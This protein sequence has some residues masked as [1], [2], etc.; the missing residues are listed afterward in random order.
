MKVLSTKILSETQK[1]LFKNTGIEV[2]DYDAISIEFFDFETPSVIKNGI[3]TSQNGVQS[4][5]G[6]NLKI[7][8]TFC[9]GEKTK[10]ILQENG[11]KVIK[12][13]NYGSELG[14][15]IQKNYENEVFYFFCGNRR[16]D[17]IP[18]AI[19]NSKNTL[20]EIKTYKT[21]LNTVIF[22]QKWD[23]ILFFSPS[24]VESY[25]T[26][27]SIDNTPVF[28]IGNTTASEAKLHSKNSIYIAEETTVESVIEKAIKTLK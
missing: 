20:F 9:V 18:S 21:E 27:N 11:E 17:E 24:G 23:G 6:K 5:C 19:N 7:K 15:F 26:K 25:I 10:Q 16:R 3:F 1:A 4:I 13:F 12:M 8:N 22:D 2:I 28:C 14:D